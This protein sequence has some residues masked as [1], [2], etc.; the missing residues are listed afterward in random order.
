MARASRIDDR[1]NAGTDAKNIG[2]H[3]EDAETIH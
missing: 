3:A 2:V 1:R